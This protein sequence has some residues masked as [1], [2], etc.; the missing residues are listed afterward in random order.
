MSWHGQ[1]TLSAAM[2]QQRGIAPAGAVRLKESEGEL[3]L[4]P[5][6]MLQVARYKNI[7]LMVHL[8]G[9]FVAPP[10]LCS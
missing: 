5:A 4:K 6:A 9:V 2:G 10:V 1:I 7:E 8:N 3:Q